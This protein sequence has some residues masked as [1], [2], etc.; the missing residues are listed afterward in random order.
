MV[1]SFLT[2]WHRKRILRQHRIPNE[3]W[4][5]VIG[6]VRAAAHLAAVDIERL[7]DMASL[8]L[9]EKSIEPAHGFEITDAM[10]ARIGCEAAIPILNLGLEY[11]HL[12]HSVIVYPAAFVARDVYED[13]AGVI[14]SQPS[15]REGEAWQRG[16]VII[17][18]EDVYAHKAE[19]NVIIHEMAHKLDM[20]DGVANGRPPLQFGMDQEQW[21]AAFSEAFATHTAQVDAGLMTEID[22][23]AASDPAEFFAVTS[24]VFFETPRVLQRIWPKVYEQLAL[25]YRQRP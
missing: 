9:Y 7:H 22:A 2:S 5:S 18:W 3:L 23:Y 25:Y 15:A 20:L 6:Q 11:Y 12:W 21:T 1:F 19:G 4:Q 10:R 13:D 14:H 17:S 8:F 16:P 24:E